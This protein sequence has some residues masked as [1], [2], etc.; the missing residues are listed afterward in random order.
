[1]AKVTQ[2]QLIEQ[3]QKQI[4]VKAGYKA[5]D[6][7]IQKLNDEISEMID[8]ADRALRIVL[9]ICRWKNILIY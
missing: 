9:N 8:N 4:G 5:K 3:Q 6:I 1:M 7:L 2:K